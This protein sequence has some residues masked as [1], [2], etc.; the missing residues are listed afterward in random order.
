[1]ERK[2]RWGVV[3]SGGIARR[4]TIPEGILPSRNG[5]LAAVYGT[6]QKTNAEVAAQFQA[7]ACGSLDELL[8][9]EIDAVYIASPVK[10]HLEQVLACARARKNVLCEKPMGRTVLEVEEMVAACRGAGVHLGVAF[11]MRFHSQH[12]AAL[13]IIRS[14]RLGKPVFGRAQLSCWYPPSPGAFRQD[15]EL[16]GGGALVDLGSHCIDLLEMF[17]GPVI[18]LSCFINHTIH[19]YA[20]EDSAVTMLSFANGALAAVDTFFCI[21]DDSSKNVLE[22]YGSRGSILA[23]GTIG[24]G[25]QGQMLAYFQD[26]S[27]NYEAGQTRVAARGSTIAPHPVNTYRAEIEAFGDTILEGKPNL[28][29]AESGLRNQRIMAACYESARS[30]RA[31]EIKP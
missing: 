11:M 22:L 25:S 9:S 29:S 3:G 15:P 31:V 23:T 2:V 19:D 18:R 20:S 6:N 24:Q 17:F 8:K 1:M 4:R 5:E 10:P 28:L 27:G 12:Q 7:R 30:G 26:D 13:E 16:G 21:Q 14:G